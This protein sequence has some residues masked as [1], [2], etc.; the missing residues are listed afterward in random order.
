M[1]FYPIGPG[2]AAVAPETR[3]QRVAREQQ[4]RRE[5]RLKTERE[6]SRKRG[7]VKRRHTETYED[8][9]D[10]LGLSVDR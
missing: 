8:R 7:L 9:L 1:M 10:D 5:A 6:R 4:E 2:G 3:Y